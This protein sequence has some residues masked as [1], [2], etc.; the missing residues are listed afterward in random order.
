MK[1][2]RKLILGTA[3]ATI[4]FA[5]LDSI[6]S[7]QTAPAAA[8]AP[9]PM[10]MP[11]M[12]GPS[13]NPAPLSFDL[14][15]SGLDFLIGKVYVTGALTGMAYGQTNSLSVSGDRDVYAD[16]TNGQVVVQKTDGFFQWYVE[17]GAYSFPTIGVPYVSSGP[18]TG[19]TFSAVPEA[20]IKLAFTDSF[21]VEA[22]KLPTLIGNEYNFTFQNMNVQRGLL[23]N[24]EPAVSRGVQA[25][26]S[27]GPLTISLSLN[28]G[29]YTDRY[30]VLSGLISYAF[31]GGADTLAFAGS[32]NLGTTDF[33]SKS[34]TAPIFNSDTIYNLIYTH[35]SG[36]WT[37]SPYLQYLSVPKSALLGSATKGGSSTSG[38]VLISYALND[39]WKLPF[40][41][42][43][44]STSGN[45]NLLYGKGSNAFSFT[46][47]PTYQYKVF[48]VR[49]EVS[50]V[51]AGSTTSG[52]AIGPTGKST[53][54]FRFILESGIV[55]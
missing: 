27:S 34:G 30:N 10:A 47:T 16:L 4:A 38:A 43:Y 12:S 24:Q 11:S 36:A 53:D 55:F 44:V 51:S 13:A 19:A 25:N 39:N 52:L 8:P 14:S 29:Y 23:W 9:A 21:N 6:A 22:G 49:P 5:S 17:A 15:G 46:V 50:Y 20:F 42:E 37:I 31:N 7:A 40:R 32:G 54:Q 2:L 28:D 3:S 33:F 48:F 35:T 41:F 1:N 18:T 45:Y 26:Y